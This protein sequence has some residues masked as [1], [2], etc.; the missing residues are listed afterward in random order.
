VNSSVVNAFTKPSLSSIAPSTFPVAIKASIQEDVKTAMRAGEKARLGTLRLILAAIKQREV[1][2]RIT[3][4]DAQTLTVLEKMVKQRRESI[5]QFEKGERIDLADK[6][7]AELEIVR[8]Y[9][10]EPLD[11]A[12]LDALIEAA[13]TETG[14]ASLRDMGKVM[15]VLKQRAQGQADFADVSRRVKARLSA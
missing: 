9:M 8:A 10:P 12:A 6:E 11:S 14:A 7:R 4:D 2:E 15:A 3:L 1:D 13:F 5:E